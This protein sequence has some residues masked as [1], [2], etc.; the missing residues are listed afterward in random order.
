MLQCSA[1]EISV[2]VFAHQKPVKKLYKNLYSAKIQLFA[3]FIQQ[4][5]WAKNCTPVSKSKIIKC[6]MKGIK[7]SQ[8]A[9]IFIQISRRSRQGC[10]RHIL[11]N[12]CGLDCT[13][14]ICPGCSGRLRVAAIAVESGACKVESGAYKVESSTCKS[15]E[16]NL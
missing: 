13:R 7:L 9:M 1:A 6:C 3:Q 2:Q 10:L 4:K 16:W 11:T 5:R 12:A 15:R 8:P 14:L